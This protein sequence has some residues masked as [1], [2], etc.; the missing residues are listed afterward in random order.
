MK[1]WHFVINI[2]WALISSGLILV[3]S[4]QDKEWFIDGEGINNICDVMKYVENDDVRFGGMLM[5][6]PLFFLIYT[7]YLKRKE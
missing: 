6:L 1:K 4:T 2:V 5:T 7:F 3:L